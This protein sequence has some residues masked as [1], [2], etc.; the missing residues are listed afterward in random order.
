MKQDTPLVTRRFPGLA[1]QAVLVVAVVGWSSSTLAEVPTMADSQWAISYGK[2]KPA[3]IGHDEA[4]WSKHR[5][6]ADMADQA[7]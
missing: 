4:A 5:A 3:A 2:E 1:F 6:A 7:R